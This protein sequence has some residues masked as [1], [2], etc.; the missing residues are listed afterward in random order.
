VVQEIIIM[1]IVVQLNLVQQILAVVE[2]EM[3][4]QVALV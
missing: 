3:V 1:L 2:V 4:E